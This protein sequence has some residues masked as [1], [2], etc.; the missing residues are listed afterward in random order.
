MDKLAFFLDADVP[1][2]KRTER[3]NGILHGLR[4]S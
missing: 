1:G 2:G 4:F 3:G